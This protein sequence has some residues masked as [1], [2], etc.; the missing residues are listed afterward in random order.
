MASV[1]HALTDYKDR[2]LATAA[3]WA[4][5]ALDDIV[6]PAGAEVEYI[7]H[8]IAP[9]ILMKMFDGGALP[10]PMVDTAFSKKNALTPHLWG[11][12]YDSWKPTPADGN[13]VFLTAL[14]DR[15]DDNLRKR[16]FF[17][18]VTPDLYK[19]MYRGKILA[20]LDRLF[21]PDN[22]GKPFMQLY[23]D[24]YCDLYWDLHLG[25]TGGAIPDDVRK[26][27]SS[28]HGV[29]SHSSPWQPEFHNNYMT[30]RALRPAMM[31]WIA[32]GIDAVAAGTT[33]EADK[34]F[35][36]YWLRNA[37]GHEQVFTRK[38]MAFECFSDLLAMSQWGQTIYLLIRKLSQPPGQEDADDYRSHIAAA[39]QASPD[40]GQAPGQTP[41]LRVVH[42]IYRLL[43][44]NFGS[45]S[46]LAV[47]KLDESKPFG[48]EFAVV[49]HAL[50]CTAPAQ[51]KNPGA[52]DPDRYLTAPTS[53]QIGQDFAAGAGLAKCPFDITAFPVSDGRD[54][55]IKNSGFG[56]VY[57]E[58][59][60]HPMP[61]IDHAG[62]APFGFGYRRCPGEQLSHQFLGEFLQETARRN[63]VFRDLNLA[64]PTMVPT[65]PGSVMPDQYGFF[66]GA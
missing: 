63:I 64:D 28:F 37:A 61:V 20:F 48:A 26:L 51:W 11:I 38:D 36:Y 8:V 23:A 22:A 46:P 18:A 4:K 7:E 34:T 17:S 21:A 41:I 1:L 52:F 47:S 9:A 5:R 32:S 16:L 3:D 2:I 58:I 65:G 55:T 44:P 25:L 29:I 42:E 66:A 31:A 54:V 50:N 24:A 33:P 14:E 45:I 27:V 56:T 43:C 6:I 40:G 12:F 15:G 13:S 10:L 59:G 62:F 53:A 30:I 35:V 39:L 57:G 49:P 19:T 60:G